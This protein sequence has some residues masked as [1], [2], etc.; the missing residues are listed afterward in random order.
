MLQLSRYTLVRQAVL[1]IR[2]DY[3]IDA[4][5]ACWDVTYTLRKYVIQPEQ[6][7]RSK[8]TKL[9]RKLHFETQCVLLGTGIPQDETKNGGFCGKLPG[10]TRNPFP[11][12]ARKDSKLCQNVW[13]LDKGHIFFSC[14][15][16]RNKLTVVRTHF[17]IIYIEPCYISLR[18][19]HAVHEAAYKSYNNFI[20]LKDPPCR[21]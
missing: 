6:I 19:M 13:A 10:P 5:V 21:I 9:T 7:M 2:S 12:T 3:V 17:W 8:W 4:C 20:T 14:F 15:F 18:W 16:S 11:K 1:N